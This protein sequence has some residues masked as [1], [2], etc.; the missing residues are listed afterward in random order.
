M[1]WWCVDFL[2]YC[3][4]FPLP[5]SSLFPFSSAFRA[6][7]SIPS[8]VSWLPCSLVSSIPSRPHGPRWGRQWGGTQGYFSGGQDAAWCLVLWDM[9]TCRGHTLDSNQ[10]GGLGSTGGTVV[11]VKTRAAAPALG[12]GD[13]PCTA[14]RL[15]FVHAEWRPNQWVTLVLIHDFNLNSTWAVSCIRVVKNLRPHDLQQNPE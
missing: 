15:G 8:L 12:P 7:P 1:D 14:P 11:R 9:H 10:A 2:T 13:G 4:F 3:C 5:P 6:V